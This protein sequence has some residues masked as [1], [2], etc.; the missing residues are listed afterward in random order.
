MLARVTEEFLLETVDS[1][2][3]PVNPSA[4]RSKLML[5]IGALLGGAIGFAIAIGEDV[6]TRLRATLAEYRALEGEA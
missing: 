4:P 5:V 3:P 1:A 2:S 6:V